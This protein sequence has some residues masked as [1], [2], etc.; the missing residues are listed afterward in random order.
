VVGMYKLE[1]DSWAGHPKNMVFAVSS[2]VV[3]E[4]RE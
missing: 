3:Y 4:F 1:W 2:V